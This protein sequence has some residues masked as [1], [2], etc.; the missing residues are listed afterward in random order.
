M[1]WAPTWPR[2]RSPAGST[3]S[4]T[5]ILSPTRALRFGKTGRSLDGCRAGAG[6]A[7][8]RG[9]RRH[10]GHTT[11]TGPER[12][13][14]DD[15]RLSRDSRRVPDGENSHARVHAG[16]LL[17][18]PRFHPATR[19]SRS[20]RGDALLRSAGDSTPRSAGRS[21]VF[22]A[23]S[24]VEVVPVGRRARGQRRDLLSA[25][26]W[27]LNS[28]ARRCSHAVETELRS[29][30][31]TRSTSSLHGAMGAGGDLDPEG[32]ASRPR[33]GAWPA[34]RQADRR[35]RSTSTAS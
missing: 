30:P 9:R 23:R 28:L 16:D 8:R 20:R 3:T 26:G 21:S 24:D 17:L 29:G 11:T 2:G 15:R 22:D 19:T 27:R 4:R 13:P 33:S 10:G 12:P 32:Y 14:A 34:P 6:G 7:G 25:E 5:S 18:Q 31:P 35:S 1:T